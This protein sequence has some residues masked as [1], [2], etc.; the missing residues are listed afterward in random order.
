MNPNVSL[1]GY[2][3]AGA[4]FGA[5]VLI[6][7]LS[8]RH[9]RARAFLAD[10]K[11]PVRR[12]AKGVFGIITGGTDYAYE[13]KWDLRLAF[14]NS[15]EIE[16]AEDFEEVFG[17]L[18]AEAAADKERTAWQLVRAI[19]LARMAAGAGFVDPEESWRMIGPLLPRVQKAFSGWEDLGR[20]YLAARDAWIREQGLQDEPME[21][22]EKNLAALRGGVWAET[23]YDQPLSG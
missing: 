10:A 7:F 6:Y 5:I 16:T 3:F 23:P 21:D 18:A 2:L 1:K 4:F 19:N 14:Q 15:W 8:G 13:G 9:K 11:D 12:W 22:V 17:E 20:S